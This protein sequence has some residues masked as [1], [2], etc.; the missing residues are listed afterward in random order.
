MSGLPTQKTIYTF[1]YNPNDPRIMYASL[2]GGIFLSKDEGKQWA[3]LEEGPKGV[4]A[5]A[6]HPKDSSKIFAA[7]DDGEIFLSKDG[8]YAWKVQNR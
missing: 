1:A 8:G 3:L 4:V 7:T 6:I 2:R 5:I